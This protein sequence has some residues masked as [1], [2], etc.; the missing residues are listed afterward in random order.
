MYIIIIVHVAVG[1]GQT[2]VNSIENTTEMFLI[3]N[4]GLQR[5]NLIHK[6]YFKIKQWKLKKKNKK[7]LLFL[8]KHFTC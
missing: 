5:S 1:L 3:T 8:F 7:K 4:A 2:A 6:D